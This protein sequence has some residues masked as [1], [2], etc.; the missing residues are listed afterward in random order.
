MG[1][2]HSERPF[3]CH[4]LWWSRGRVTAARRGVPGKRQ[5][6]VR[7]LRHKVEG[8]FQTTSDLGNGF[9]NSGGDVFE[10]TAL[11]KE[12][13]SLSAWSA[14]VSASRTLIGM[15]IRAVLHGQDH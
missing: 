5:V 11:R 1:F 4:L 6:G 9:E 15:L 8:T 10:D 2:R 12:F 13:Q 7:A 3:I 14:R